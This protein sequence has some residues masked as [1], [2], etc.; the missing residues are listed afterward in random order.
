MSLD[1]L[2]RVNRV[3]MVADREPIPSHLYG[4]PPELYLDLTW[5]DPAIGVYDYGWWPPQI[6]LPPLTEYQS[7]GQET[8]TADAVNR[9]VHVGYAVR[10][11][12][13][14]EITAHKSAKAEIFRVATELKVAQE[15]DNFAKTRGYDSIL[16][17]CSYATSSVPK[18]Q[19]EGAR[20]M[21]L[22]DASWVKA[23]ET[24]TAVT[25]HEIP[26]PAYEDIGMP[27][28]EWEVPVVPPVNP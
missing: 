10:D 19:V 23:Y 13:P 25:A 11:W 15:L 18:Y 26:P 1:T 24:I 5:L 16:S 22:R 12:T 3:T 8:L 2:I 27:V 14:E 4:F 28:L 21:T 9:V 7:L 20:A 6:V 17:A